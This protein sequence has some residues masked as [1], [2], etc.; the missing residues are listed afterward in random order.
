MER[1]L[2]RV[3]YGG[4]G[5]GAALAP[6]AWLYAGVAGVRRSA[7]ARGWL[8]T[9]A[10]GSPVAVVGNLTVG[11]TGKT[12]LTLWLAGALAAQGIAVGIVSRGYGAASGA[13]R[14]V[15]ADDDWREVG[16]EPVLLAARTGAPVVVAH[17]R[18]AAAREATRLGAELILSDDGLQH[19]RMARACE[20]IVIDGARG[21][22]NGRLLPAGPL[23]E[24][25][26]RL[27]RADAIILNG[28]P[29][30]ALLKEVRRLARG[31]VVQMRLE[32]A[33]ARS[34]TRPS[35]VLPLAE[36]RGRRVHGVAGI[37]HPQRFFRELAAADIDV[38]EHAFADHHAFSAAELAFEDE[39]PILMTEKDAVR[40]RALATGRMW[41]VPVSASFSAEDER[42]LLECVRERARRAHGPAPL[43]QP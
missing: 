21:F 18:V 16:D 25:P 40:C 12:P 31:P 17:D 32:P 24:H 1:W 36:L 30:A 33:A 15:H 38:I 39:L 35:S 6:L 5:A 8:R 19:L 14:R 43:G 42:A 34:I 20:L 23:R 37:G 11:G 10:T 41:Y 13:V 7:Y 26:E 28:T 2:T 9:Q 29:S 3:W 22:G 27:A 4:G